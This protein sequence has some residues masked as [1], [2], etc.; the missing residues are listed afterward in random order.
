MD[1]FSH[2]RY[3]H[4]K[5]INFIPGGTVPKGDSNEYMKKQQEIV[6]EGITF[7]PHIRLRT[8]NEQD[9]QVIQKSK[10]IFWPDM[11]PERYDV[12]I[13]HGYNEVSTDFDQQRQR[14][15]YALEILKEQNFNIAN[16]Y[17]WSKEEEK[18]FS[19]GFPFYTKPRITPVN[20]QLL[21]S[22]KGLLVRIYEGIKQ[23]NFKEKPHLEIAIQ[24]MAK[25]KT[26]NYLDKTLDTC[27]GLEALFRLS[28]RTNKGEAIG[29]AASMLLGQDE[30]DRGE[31][32]HKIQ[33]LFRNRNRI[34]H[35]DIIPENELIE[36]RDIAD[37]GHRILRFSLMYLLPGVI[38][39]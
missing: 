36:Y 25:A 22:E 11:V 18:F 38:T 24:R 23:H 3:D 8:L 17:T 10:D 2:I 12:V 16:S 39:R 7:E 1:S 30:E 6:Q 37:S 33:R 28:V 29:L 21:S 14:I 5:E 9:I 19:F 27:I 26:Y 20:Y 34:V 31:I 4:L 15:Y 35:G 13:E 32:S